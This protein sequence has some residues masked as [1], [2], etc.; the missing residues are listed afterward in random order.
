MHTLEALHAG[1]LAGV[2]RLDLSCGLT[3]FP[4]AIF[5]LADSLEILNLSGNALSELPDDLPRLHKLRIIF[6]SDNRFTHVPE[7]LGRCPELEMIGFKA[8]RIGTLSA[9]AL[10]TKLR[11]LILTDNRLRTLP[12][13]LGLCTRLQKLML[14]GNQLQQL[15]DELANCRN[16]ELLRIAA[17][18]FE[19]LPDWLFDMPRLA[20]LACSGNPCSDINEAA[21]LAHL[22]IT[23]VEWHQLELHHKL[24]EGA[25][26]VIYRAHHHEQNAAVAVKMFKGALT[27]DGLPRSEKAASIAAGSHPGLIPVLGK[28]S[29]H[30]EQTP[31]LVMSLIDPAFRNLAGPP[32]LASCTRDI[33]ADDVRFTLP[34]AL[35]IACGIAAVA[36]HLHAQGIMHGDLY[37]HNILWDDAGDCLLGDFGAAS[38]LPQDAQQAEAMQRIEVRAYACLLQELLDRIDATPADDTTLT[39]LRTLQQRCDAAHVAA[40][41]LFTEIHRALTALTPDQ[42]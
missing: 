9:A 32:S 34:V 11:W 16:L 17:N 12:P 3:E 15:P 24:G 5:E 13:E 26:G 10:P 1:E 6:C 21:A 35:N 22:H 20:W 8:N 33:Y 29:D 14:A 18:R 7:V 27:S 19:H 2:K 4:R 36:E 30:P 38:F 41:P 40:R 25:S 37:A 42:A 31:G 39:T 23:P 28:I